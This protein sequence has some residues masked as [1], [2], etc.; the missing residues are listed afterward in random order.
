MIVIDDRLEVTKEFLIILVSTMTL[1][2]LIIAYQFRLERVAEQDSRYRLLG[3]L[4]TPTGKH[5][6][7][8]LMI[9]AV[10]FIILILIFM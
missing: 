9:T 10:I 1:F 7:L 2:G 4:R 3:I 8:L 6:S 5:T